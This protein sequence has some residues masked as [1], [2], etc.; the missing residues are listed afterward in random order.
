MKKQGAILQAAGSD[1]ASG[2]GSATDNRASAGAGASAWPPRGAAAFAAAAAVA[3]AAPKSVDAKDLPALPME[4]KSVWGP[5]G[6]K[7]KAAPRALPKRPGAQSSQSSAV[8]AA[9]RAA[10]MTAK[11]AGQA[12][13][14]RL[15]KEAVALLRRI[16]A[17]GAPP[18]QEVLEE[19]ANVLAKAHVRGAGIGSGRGAVGQR[20][21]AE[22]SSSLAEAAE[23][24]PRKLRGRTKRHGW[25][26]DTMIDRQAKTREERSPRAKAS[27]SGGL[28]YS[29]PR[30]GLPAREGYI[31]AGEGQWLAVLD[32]ARGLLEREF[33]A[34]GEG[35]G[36]AMVLRPADLAQGSGAGAGESARSLLIV[37][38][39]SASKGGPGSDGGSA[40]ALA[41][42]PP[43]S[44]QQQPQNEGGASLPGTPRLGLEMEGAGAG[45]LNADADPA[46]IAAELAATAATPTAV[47][48]YK[49]RAVA[50]AAAEG[51]APERSGGKSRGPKGPDGDFFSVFE[52]SNPPPKLGVPGAGAAGAAARTPS[53][54]HP[55]RSGVPLEITST[56]LHAGATS[57]R[58][59]LEREAFDPFGFSVAQDGQEQGVG[60][61]P[62]DDIASASDVARALAAAGVPITL[63]PGPS[64]VA[65]TSPPKAAAVAAPATATQM[66][67]ATPDEGLESV[68]V[69]MA[70]TVDSMAPEQRRVLMAELLEKL[71]AVDS[72][73]AEVRRK[74]LHEPG[75]GGSSRQG[76]QL[77]PLVAD[78]GGTPTVDFVGAAMPSAAPALSRIEAERITRARD[79]FLSWLEQGDLALAGD[80]G[81]NLVATVEAASEALLEEILADV[82]EKEI[83]S[84]CA[85]MMESMLAQE[86]RAA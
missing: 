16:R 64:A 8:H 7:R 78:A 24:R 49:Q 44:L 43:L 59:P 60:E 63:P 66:Q 27:P 39:V 81:F 70:L 46:A 54:A 73:E 80:E 50:M 18:T 48:Q 77:G 26:A 31:A 36:A 9:K 11:A 38:D 12:D 55:A 20:A 62:M 68:L 4:R 86:F 56:P 23:E 53:R 67:V 79:V 42:A 41:A 57:S 51:Q 29:K 6:G 13:T 19:V 14:A 17:A 74:W 37:P 52:G 72:F 82:A 47:E 10:A 28:R 61:A 35:S 3:A 5:A 33:F 58:A 71:D 65:A 15:A 30:R 76:S 69:D 25:D 22:A 84:A 85:D 21:R 83:D 34:A 75:A 1:A 40:L 32:T 45:D 2:A